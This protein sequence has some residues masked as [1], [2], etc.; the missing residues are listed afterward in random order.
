MGDKDAKKT[1]S[2]EKNKIVRQVRQTSIVYSLS[3]SSRR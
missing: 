3:A 1:K 2:Y